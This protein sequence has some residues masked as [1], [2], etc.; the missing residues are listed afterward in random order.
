MNTC[1]CFITRICRLKDLNKFQEIVFGNPFHDFNK[2][3]HFKSMIF[4]PLITAE[5][6][7]MNDWQLGKIPSA[8]RQWKYYL[9]LFREIP[10]FALQNQSEGTPQH[11]VQSLN[12]PFFPPHVG[13]EPGRAKRESRITCMR[14]FKTNQS[15][16]TRLLSI[17]VHTCFRQRVAQYLFQ[18]ARWKKKISLVLILW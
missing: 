7:M 14:M 4:R 18:L 13:A 6:L 9:Q 15:K 16:I 11:L 10:K 2:F 12:S 8:L 5:A 3:C 17:R 1:N